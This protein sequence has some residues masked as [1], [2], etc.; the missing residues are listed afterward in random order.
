MTGFHEYAWRRFGLTW[1]DLVAEGRE[2]MVD[3]NGSY[4]KEPSAKALPFWTRIAEFAALVEQVAYDWCEEMEVARPVTT[5]TAKPAGT[6]S[7]LF[8]LTEGVHLPPMAE[9]LRWV[10]FR[11]DDPIAAE[12]EARGYPTRR[13]LNTYKGVTLVGF[14]TQPTICTLGMGDGLVT[15][16][17]ATPEEQFRFLRLL[18]TYWLGRD[19]GNQISYTLKYYPTIVSYDDY[20]AVVLENMPKVRAV[21]VMPQIDATAYEYQPEEAI[22]REQYD[23]ADGGGSHARS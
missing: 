18:E 11:D 1:K 17:E 22:T 4:M 10:Q 2:W 5:R 15:A 16:A 23:R 20:K 7:K 13:N 6:T 12:Y 14:P 8:G 21:S 3:G 9:Y 19:G